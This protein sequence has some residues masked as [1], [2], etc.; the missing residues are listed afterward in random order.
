MPPF[1]SRGQQQLLQRGLRRPLCQQERKGVHAAAQGL[2]H[3]TAAHK[4]MNKRLAGPSSRQPY[5]AAKQTNQT[6]SHCSIFFCRNASSM[7]SVPSTRSISKLL[8]MSTWR[9]GGGAAGGMEA[10]AELGGPRRRHGPCAQAMGC[11]AAGH[12]DRT[13]ANLCRRTPIPHAPAYRAPR[14]R[15]QQAA[16]HAHASA[17]A[18]AAG[19]RGGGLARGSTLVG[20]RARVVVRD[21][22]QHQLQSGPSKETREVWAQEAEREEAA[23]ARNGGGA[24]VRRH[25]ARG[26]LGMLQAAISNQ[27]C[28]IEASRFSP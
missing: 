5:N 20:Q 24:A 23:A 16:Q 21:V 4:P 15:A 2:S 6:H 22:D 9:G 27:Q 19:R 28:C 11:R 3:A 10:V 25:A 7:S 1:P 8:E 17:V 18:A 26:A 12:K 13:A 14:L